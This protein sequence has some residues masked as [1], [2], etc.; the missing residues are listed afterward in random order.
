MAL[1]VA[2]GLAIGTVRR[3]Y[4]GLDMRESHRERIERACVELQYPL[5][6]EKG[7]ERA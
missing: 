5:R 3:Y 7:G 2:T 4:E 1:A 6:G